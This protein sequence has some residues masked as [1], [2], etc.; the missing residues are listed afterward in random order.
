LSEKPRLFIWAMELPGDLDA[1]HAVLKRRIRDQSEIEDCRQ[2]FSAEKK[3][4][5]QR[6]IAA[7]VS[8]LIQA[9]TERQRQMWCLGIFLT[10]RNW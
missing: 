10:L 2:D 9:K 4:A 6:A 1:F 7:R 8:K 3:V 5:A